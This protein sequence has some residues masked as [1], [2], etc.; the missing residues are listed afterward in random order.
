MRT[1]FKM[2]DNA[3]EIQGDTLGECCDALMCKDYTCPDNT[4]WKPMDAALTATKAGNTTEECCEKLF[5]STFNCSKTDLQH[6]PNSASRQGQSEE[7]S[8]E[9]KFCKDYTCSDA[10]KWVHFSD[11]A[12]KTDV[13]RRGQTDDECCEPKFCQVASCSPVTAWRPKADIT[14]IQGSTR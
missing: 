5:C 2:K 4:Q 11:L 7:E 10:T 13:D 1:V 6:K 14:K 9:L 12:S 3:A 8:C